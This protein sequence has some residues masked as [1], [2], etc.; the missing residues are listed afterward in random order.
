MFIP[1]LLLALAPTAPVAPAPASLAEDV[2]EV[3][4]S[5]CLKHAAGELV[6]P[7]PATPEFETA[8]AALRLKTGIDR[9]T[10]DMFGPATD[11]IARAA[12]AHRTDGVSSVVLAADGAMPGC[13]VILLGDPSADTADAVAAALV[14][15]GSG[16]WRAFPE[17]TASRGPVTKRVFLRRD[18]K[19]KVYLLNLVVLTQPIGKIQLYTT[20]VAV[21]PG[22]TLP[23]GF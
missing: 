22:V 16:G 10:F 14:R 23:E 17:M 8:V 13:R 18:A 9:R 2:A 21:P 11:F 5:A 3:S 20:T 7:H 6:F 4:N 19:G 12:M 1:A 15:S